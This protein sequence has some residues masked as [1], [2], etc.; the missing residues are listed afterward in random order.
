MS[1]ALLKSV[2][3]WQTFASAD[4]LLNKQNTIARA[5]SL[6]LDRPTTREIQS[7]LDT[8]EIDLDLIQRSA[9]FRRLDESADS[10]FYSY[11]RFVEHIDAAAVTSLIDFHRDQFISLAKA[12]QSSLPSQLNVLDVCSSWVSHLPSD[13]YT[14]NLAVDTQPPLQCD[15]NTLS[16][17][18]QKGGAVLGVGMN[19]DELRR[20]PQL[21]S[22]LVQDL[23]LTPALDPAAVPTGA[24]DVALIQLSIDYL[25][26]PVEVLE[27]VLATLRPGGKLIIRLVLGH[28]CIYTRILIIHLL[29]LC[30]VYTSYLYLAS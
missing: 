22:Y 30:T 10:N 23:N 24:F 21:S 2:L 6:P 27:G 14:P 13:L 15:K 4:S 20:N 7:V 11:P 19:A 1:S 25:T 18:L 8:N 17:L 5:A 3:A 12:L 26:Q 28:Y 29:T 16:P 9:N